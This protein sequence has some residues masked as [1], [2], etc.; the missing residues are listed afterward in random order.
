MKTIRDVAIIGGGP[1][2]LTAALTLA[3]GGRFVTV[4][5]TNLGRNF[6]AEHMMNFPSR[7]GTSPQEFR[8][9][10]WS[11]LSKYNEVERQNLKVT[12]I[13][14]DGEHFIV[15]EKYTFRKIL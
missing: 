3:R 10:I 15:N 13:T 12:D 9:L 5:D 1:A 2:G 8:N 11:D 4:F 6:P 14:K 7:E